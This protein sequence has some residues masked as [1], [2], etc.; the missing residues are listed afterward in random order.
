MVDSEAHKYREL[1]ESMKKNP[2]I[3]LGK[4]FSK[5]E[6]KAMAFFLNGLNRSI[7]ELTEETNNKF[8]GDYKKW[9]KD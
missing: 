7:D 6:L 5:V 2:N 1:Y 9:S 4:S 3:K 8:Y